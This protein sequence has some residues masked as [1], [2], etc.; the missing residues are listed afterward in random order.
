MLVPAADD[1]ST[2]NLY[3][4]NK[5]DSGNPL[6][7]A[8]FEAATA[9]NPNLKSWH[10]EGPVWGAPDGCGYVFTFNNQKPPWNN[11][12][13]RIAIN[14]AI[15]RKQI[16]ELGYQN[17]NYPI[18]APF[19]SYMTSRWVTPG[20][21]LQAV[22]DKYNR[23]TPDPEQVAQHMQAAGYAKDA[24]GMWSK[25][26][27]T[28]KIPVRGPQFFAPLG[29][30]LAE[31]LK[32]AGF[33]ATAIIEPNSSTAWNDDLLTGQ[34]DTIFFVH[35]GSLTEPWETLNDLN[36]KFSRPIGEKCPNSIA[37]TRYQNPEYDALVNDMETMVGTPD[38]QKYMD[39]A[40]KALDIY[41]RDMPEIM[42]L[43][44]AARRHVQQ[45]LL[46]GLGQREGPLRRAL[47]VLGGLEPDRAQD[48]A[49]PV[50]SRPVPVGYIVKRVLQL[51]LIVWVAVT[52]NFI[53]PRLIPGDPVESAL[54]TKMAMTG[55][56]QRRRAGR[57]RRLPRE[58]RAG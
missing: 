26:G 11:A 49:N 38:N 54:Q 14:Y 42:L 18:V 10:A 34:S 48:P 1:Q 3:I 17:A 28:L 7:P 50:G 43:R 21:P 41:L 55:Q 5:A 12:D 44:G 47:P 58:V 22:I 13:V 32:K 6:Q 23:G 52:V 24:N 31:Q 37:C 33:D 20:S 35:C 15:D 57:G 2:A 46:D 4:G 25:D 16:S 51:I 29:P 53:I 39:D 8:T 36:S 40:V 19:S 27:Q 9:R 56:R 45:H 30:P